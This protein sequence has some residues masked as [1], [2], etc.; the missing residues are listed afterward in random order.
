MAPQAMDTPN[1][2]EVW[3][4][5]AEH[6]EDWPHEFAMG[7]V[8]RGFDADAQVEGKIIGMEHQQTT[9]VLH[10][11]DMSHQARARNATIIGANAQ[12]SPTIM[13]NDS[14]QGSFCCVLDSPNESNK[15]QQSRDSA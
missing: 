13:F 14:S 10:T 9:P 8:V 7:I 1:I 15:S 2:L 5:L 3:R 11:H 6:Y 4:R 12:V